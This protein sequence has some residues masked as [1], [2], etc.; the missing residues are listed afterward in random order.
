MDIKPVAGTRWS[1]AAAG[2][3]ASSGNN[4]QS[5][6][7]ALLEIAEG[8]AL[9]GVFTQNAFC[10]APVIV[11]KA[12]LK[13]IAADSAGEL[14]CLINS[15]NANAGT[16][17]AGMDAAEKSC[18]VMANLTDVNPSNVLPFSTGVIGELLPVEKISAASEGLIEGL[19]EDG[20]YAAARAIMT[21][22]TIPKGCSRTILVDGVEIVVSG[23]AKG[24]GMIKPNMATMLAFIATDAAVAQADLQ[25]VLSQSVAVSFNRITVDGDTST[26]DACTIAATGKSGVSLN[27]QHADWEKFSSAVI[28][29]MQELATA[30]IRDAEGASKFITLDVVNGASSDECLK[31]AYAVAESPLVKTAFFASDANWGRI[32]AAVG[33]AGIDALDVSG[34]QIALDGYVICEKGG[35]ADSY[36]EARATEIM[37][38]PDIMINI[39]LGRGQSKERVWTSDL[40]HDYVRINAEY[41]T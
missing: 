31:V 39:D 3:K 4:Q 24:A 40:S 9:A 7:L 35:R 2:I 18:Q 5:L 20:W 13:S 6:D 33:R 37:S 22:D 30:I 11:S 10:A 14:Y 26:N 38:R 1:V 28:E 36:N 27:P 19:A 34:V 25:D 21:T 41:R 8:S 16:G 12:H 23:I 29:L 32:L 17:K 15:G